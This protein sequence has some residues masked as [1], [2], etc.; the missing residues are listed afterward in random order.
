MTLLP[1]LRNPKTKRLAFGFLVAQALFAVL[2]FRYA[3]LSKLP[4]DYRSF[5]TSLGL[6]LP[7]LWIAAIDFASSPARGDGK[8][9]SADLRFSPAP[10]FY[11]AI[12]I[13]LLYSAFSAMHQAVKG[14]VTF[15]AAEIAGI[16]ITLLTHLGVFSVIFLMLAG[17]FAVWRRWVPLRARFLAFCTVGFIVGA[18]IVRKLILAPLSFY[19]PWATAYSIVLAFSVVVFIAGLVWRNA[20][21]SR[22]SATD[23]NRKGAFAAPG[24]YIWLVCLGAIAYFGPNMIGAM[25]W[26]QLLQKLFT[27]LLWVAVFILF[28]R[29]I[30]KARGRTDPNSRF[31]L[32]TAAV[33][34]LVTIAGYVAFNAPGSPLPGLQIAGSSDLENVIEQYAG[35]DLSYKVARDI[36]TPSMYD[37]SYQA[38]YTFL[39]QNSELPESVHADSVDIKLVDELKPS[40]IK[41]KPNLFVF[42]IDSLRRDY[43]SSYNKSVTFTP[44]L[45]AFGRESVVME[46]AFT[47]YSGTVLSEPAIWTGT[48]QLHKQYITPFAPMN[49][50]QKLMDMDGYD[51]WVSMDPVVQIIMREDPA[52]IRNELDKQTGRWVNLDL[53]GTAREIESRLEHRAADAKPVFVYTQSQNL[54]PVRL[55]RTRMGA[56]KVVYKKSYPGFDPLYASE[57][58]RIDQGFGEFIQFLKSHDLYD[59]SIVV[60][61]SDHGDSLGEFG[62]WGH[63]QNMFPEV[64]RIP[65]MIHLPS[66]MQQNLYTDPKAISFSM[67]VTPSLYYLLG[68]KPIAND[69]LFGRPLFTE[70]KQEHDSYLRDSY[71][72]VSSYGAVYAT[73]RDHGQSLFIV[74]AVAYK[75]YF[76]DLSRDPRT[77]HS[78]LTREVLADNEAFIRH[79]INA[80]NKFYNVRSS[81]PVA[82]AQKN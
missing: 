65:L 39:Q 45:E 79:S 75:N 11:S 63:V 62:R 46:N 61:T 76:Y 30:D 34:A 33:L 64:I 58:E 70:T 69:E 3:F 80:I 43:V 40:P 37:S 6:M 41:K 81:E 26:N 32:I 82:T 28:Y 68:H 14:E 5:L 19:S 20:S 15:G 22:T 12:F 9:E 72:L 67:D 74:D 77:M 48:L 17:A 53:S 21:W 10:A 29:N 8:N 27:I 66:A 42:V 57:L 52:I 35:R 2:Y 16:A 13:A 59:N 56:T 71:L 50:L 36:L 24:R 55:M 18:V 49:S 44:N 7:L 25:D 73:L 4:N 1:D 51:Q 54:H 23:R 78:R 31:A 47:R 38:F 60:V